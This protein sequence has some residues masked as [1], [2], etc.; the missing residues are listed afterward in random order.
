MD[1][2]ETPIPCDFREIPGQAR[3]HTL[4]PPLFVYRNTANVTVGQHARR[5]DAFAVADRRQHVHTF[6]IPTVEVQG[7]G[8]AL[9]DAEDR[10]SDRT[11]RGAVLLPPGKPNLQPIGRNH[12][13]FTKLR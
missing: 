12:G 6:V 5:A 11:D 7:L 2:L 10:I 1:R 8:N 3:T 13:V 9:L 4:P